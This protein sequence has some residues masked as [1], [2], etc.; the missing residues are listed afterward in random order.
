MLRCEE[1][2]E[3]T[4][5]YAATHA[6]ATGDMLERWTNGKYKSTKHRVVNI[7]GKERFSIPF[8]FGES[9]KSCV[10]FGCLQS[11]R[12]TYDQQMGTGLTGCLEWSTLGN[13]DW[14]EIWSHELLHVCVLIPKT[15]GHDFGHESWWY[16]IPRF[17][18]GIPGGSVPASLKGTVRL[19]S[20]WR[21]VSSISLSLTNL[22]NQTNRKATRV[23]FNLCPPAQTPTGEGLNIVSCSKCWALPPETFISISEIPASALAVSYHVTALRSLSRKHCFSAKMINVIVIISCMLLLKQAMR[24][25]TTYTYYVSLWQSECSAS[26]SESFLICTM[27]GTNLSSCAQVGLD[28]TNHPHMHAGELQPQI[29]GCQRPC[30]QCVDVDLCG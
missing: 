5:L 2:F 20:S 15:C 3:D 1:S 8:F 26:M 17:Q 10:I 30:L 28:W 12:L 13:F 11:A 29:I 22:C 14:P 6:F 9:P 27:G 25:A 18:K 19:R 4:N 7:S 16:V 24:S 23:G 21:L